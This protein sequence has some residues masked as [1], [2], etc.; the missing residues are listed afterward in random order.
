MKNQNKMNTQICVGQR[1]FTC[2]S[3]GLV[4]MEYAPDG[5]FEDRRSLVAAAGQQPAPFAAVEEQD[6]VLTLRTGRMTIVAREQSKPFFPANLEIRWEQDGLPQSWRPGDVDRRNLGG[7]VRCLDGFG[8]E[9]TMASPPPTPTPP[10]RPASRRW[11]SPEWSHLRS[12]KWSRPTKRGR[13]QIG[14]R[15]CA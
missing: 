12:L 13:H 7:T 8:R 15:S 2:L 1:R 11:R 6:G 4:R 9:A 14:H 3:S 5:R 10:P